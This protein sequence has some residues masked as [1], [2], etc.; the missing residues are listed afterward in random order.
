M[1][2][3]N[4]SSGLSHT[5]THNSINE[6]LPAGDTIASSSLPSNEKQRGKRGIIRFVNDRFPSKVH[7]LGRQPDPSHDGADKSH[8]SDPNSQKRI[9]L[10]IFSRNKTKRPEVERIS[11]GA[12]KLDEIIQEL[13]NNPIEAEAFKAQ[14]IPADGQPEWIQRSQHLI[15]HMMEQPSFHYAIIVLIIIDLIIVF[16]ELVVGEL[17]F[18]VFCSCKG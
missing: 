4:T 11:I 6:T 8:G 10:S 12:R 18:I 2:H 13:N 9:F 16:V 7:P 14:K 1:E 5:D 15:A 3:T 17:P